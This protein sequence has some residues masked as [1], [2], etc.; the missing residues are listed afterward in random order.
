MPAEQLALGLIALCV[1]VQF[2]YLSDPQSVPGEIAESVLAGFFGRVVF[3][4]S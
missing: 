2:F 4:V 1:G 3:G